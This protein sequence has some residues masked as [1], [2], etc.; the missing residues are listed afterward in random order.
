MKLISVCFVLAVGTMPMSSFAQGLGRLDEGVLIEVP[1]KSPDAPLSQLVEK[2][3]LPSAGEVHGAPPPTPVSL[4]SEWKIF[5]PTATQNPS[6]SFVGTVV[7]KDATGKY[8]STSEAIL[9][10]DKACKPPMT[11]DSKEDKV[12][13]YA[14]KVQAGASLDLGLVKLTF[15]R[16]EAVQLTLARV[17]A[18]TPTSGIDGQAVDNVKKAVDIEHNKGKYW[19]CTAQ[20]LFITTYQK[21]HKDTTGGSGAYSIVKI[22]GTYFSQADELKKL[23]NFRLQLVPLESWIH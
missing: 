17:G 4:P 12:Y 18:I 16:D 2:A 15:G 19:I 20:E 1:T 21:F 23:Y 5:T 9:L 14:R 3:T 6:A 8:T 22:D 13:T 7:I 10:V 11:V